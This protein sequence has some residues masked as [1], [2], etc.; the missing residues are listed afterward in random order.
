MVITRWVRLNVWGNLRQSFRI[1]LRAV[2]QDRDIS[3]IQQSIA[4]LSGVEDGHDIHLWSLDGPYET[5][6]AHVRSSSADPEALRRDIRQLLADREVDH[7][8]IQV[9]SGEHSCRE[10]D[11]H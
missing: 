6:T 7:C 11:S 1:F 3:A 4:A 9:E 5:F 10:E 2:P 8:T